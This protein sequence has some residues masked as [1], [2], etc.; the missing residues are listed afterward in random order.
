MDQNIDSQKKGNQGN[1]KWR[2]ERNKKKKECR[3]YRG[4][5]WEDDGRGRQE[6][7]KARGKEGKRESERN[8]MC[9]KRC[10]KCL[11]FYE[12]P[13]S[14]SQGRGVLGGHPGGWRGGARGDSWSGWRR[15]GANRLRHG[16]WSG[17]HPGTHP[18][19]W[20][21]TRDQGHSGLGIIST[22]PF[23]SHRRKHHCLQKK[24]IK[25]CYGEQE[26]NQKMVKAFSFRHPINSAWIKHE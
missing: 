22:V 17:P 20:T 13:H 23:S 6:K 18:W 25:Y 10:S 7:G 19:S 12:T 3:S 14:M 5:A 8:E 9:K 21:E 4:D 16:S 26:A 24:Y 11:A 15:K 2:R 1:G